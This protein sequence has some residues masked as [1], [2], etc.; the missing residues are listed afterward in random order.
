MNDFQTSFIPK[1][2][3]AT[4][5]SKRKR[6]VGLFMLVAVFIF[7]LTVASSV[8]AFLYKGFIERSITEKQ[9][10]LTRAQEAFEPDL[11]K[12]LAR[13]D[14]KIN[15]SKDVLEN[16]I[17][18]S[19]IFDLLEELT[20]ANVSFEAF[21]YDMED[22]NFAIQMKGVARNFS[23]L[24]LQSDVFGTNRYIVEPVFSDLDLDNLGNVTFSVS[25][26]IDR[27]LINYEDN[28]PTNF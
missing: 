4:A 8:G 7:V 6:G 20:L 13:V 24:A 14:Q 18:P 21:E 15:A 25:A 11:I 5:P 1:K 28:L 12:E 10:S 17:S 19:A 22:G 23:A 3:I 16:H 27:G 2:T 9:A 26:K